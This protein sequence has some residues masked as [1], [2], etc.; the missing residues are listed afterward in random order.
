MHGAITRL[1]E[2]LSEEYGVLTGGTELDLFRDG[3]KLKLGDKWRSKIQEALE[4]TTFFIPIVTP[5]YFASEECRNELLGFAEQAEKL[6]LEALIM[7]LYFVEVPAIENGDVDDPLVRL[8]DERHR[9]DWRT[10]RLLDATTQPY[11]TAVNRLALRLQEVSR[12]QE[13]SPPKARPSA[14]EDEEEG[15][16][17]PQDTAASQPTEH[18]VPAAATAVDS[19]MGM[20]ELLAEGEATFP[21]L[22][23]TLNSIGEEIQTVG[24]LAA[25]ATNEI[26]E[27]DA[28]GGGF[29]G[30]LSTTNRLAQR[31]KEPSMRLEQLS[32][33]YVADLLVLDPAMRQLIVLAGEQS[34]ESPED[35]DEFLSSVQEMVAGSATAASGIGGM[36][37]AL[38]GSAGISRELEVPI[39]R[40]RTSLQSMVDSQQMIDSWQEH[41]DA[42]LES[43]DN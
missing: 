18:P 29:K 32:S 16:A 6:G 36:I 19:E 31:L 3:A 43:A 10:L 33:Q 30:R 11:R 23:E 40:M 20:L 14:D 24:E 13:I 35:V 12:E 15:P 39:K 17:P 42:A 37:D 4:S 2:N 28:K 41:I 27:S 7:P 34:G 5:R 21:R 25:S 1:A 38:G 9:E 26:Q 8:I 22:V